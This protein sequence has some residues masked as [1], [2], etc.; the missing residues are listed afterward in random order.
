MSCQGCI[1][2][3]AA[4]SRSALPKAE[5][6]RLLRYLNAAHVAGYV[7]LSGTYT[8]DNFFTKINKAQRL[9][10][11][12]EL[13]RMETICMDKG[14]SCHCE[15]ISWSIAEVNKAIDNGRLEARN[16]GRYIGVIIEMKGFIATLYNMH[17]QPIQF[18]Y[19]HFVSLLSILYLP[20]FTLEVAL[21]TGY[22]K[23]LKLHEIFLYEFVA[24][25]TVFFQAIFVIGLRTMAGRLA[26]P[27][28]SDYEDL[29]V[30]TYVIDTWVMSR[31][32]LDAELPHETD[33]Y[34]E[35][36]MCEEATQLPNDQEDNDNESSAKS[37]TEKTETMS[38]HPGAIRG[39][40]S[41]EGY[42]RRHEGTGDT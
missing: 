15:L 22:T 9:L 2:N 32:M 12:S 34:V 39:R 27:Y 36:Q 25:T 31:K 41:M 20:L 1:A 19:I 14:A 40:C 28:G 4:L 42:K 5:G 8:Y 3:I 33:L 21:S 11:T 17:D 30:L 16:F 23:H 24:I 38:C 29:S 18:F 13:K 37:N 7:G 6:L 10:T 26:E 35:E